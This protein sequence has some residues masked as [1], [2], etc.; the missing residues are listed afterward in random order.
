MMAD[1]DEFR[2]D[3]KLTHLG[4]RPHDNHGVVNPPVYHASTILFP[5]VAAMEAARTERFSGTRYGRYGTPTTFAL[6]EALASIE[7][8]YRAMI[9]PSGLAAVAAALL[10]CL[11]TGDHLL[12]VDSVYGPARSFCATVLKRYGIDATFYDPALGS[13]IAG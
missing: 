6:E 1:Y 5:T 9:L 11:K 3:T 10:G 12:M 8:G 7:G 13:D 4:N 2:I